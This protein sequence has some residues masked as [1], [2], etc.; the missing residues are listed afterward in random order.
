MKK[1]KSDFLVAA[2]LLGIMALIDGEGNPIIGMFLGAAVAVHWIP[3]AMAIFFMGLGAKHLGL[4]FWWVG[5]VYVVVVVLTASVFL[6]IGGY[7][8]PTGLI[9]VGLVAAPMLL[10]WLTRK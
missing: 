9:P 6:V 10:P 2:V 8:Q 7:L 3:E 5:S 4:S 1:A